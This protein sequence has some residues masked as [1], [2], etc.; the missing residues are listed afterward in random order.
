MKEEIKETRAWFTK[1]LTE[2]AKNLV[3]KAISD[4]SGRR[5]FTD[6]ELELI[7]RGMEKRIIMV[8]G[9]KFVLSNNPERRYDAFTLNREYFTQ[10]AV[11]VE[12]IEEYG[13]KIKDCQFEYHMMDICVF[14]N[15][16]PFIYI[17]TKVSD[18]E[19]K[20]LI[21]EI[22]KKYSKNLQELQNLPDRGNDPLR[23]AKYIFSD[24]PKF[25]KVITPQNSFSYSV[26]YTKN[27][28][29]LYQ[30][31]NIPKANNSL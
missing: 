1:I 14:R 21:N 20:K 12:L 5:S 15:K 9:N 10:F 7:K 26:E 29:N 18:Y 6:K 23:K 13:Y 8:E 17:E 30:I 4:N 31:D 16:K 27:G 25:L 3:E 19:T 11:F 28:F 24:K 22:K 2:G